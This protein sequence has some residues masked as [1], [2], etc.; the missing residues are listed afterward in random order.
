MGGMGSIAMRGRK[1]IE[2]PK[3]EQQTQNL[4]ESESKRE[5]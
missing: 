4:N 3:E 1:K 2:R 5:A